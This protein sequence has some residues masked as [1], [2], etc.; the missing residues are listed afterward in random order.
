MDTKDLMKARAEQSMHYLL[1]K[2]DKI[3]DDARDSDGLTNED[4]RTLEKAWKAICVI[5]DLTKA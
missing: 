1:D 5:R 4:V 3:C 2:I